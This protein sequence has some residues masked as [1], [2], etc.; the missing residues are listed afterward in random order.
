MPKSDFESRFVRA[1][2]EFRPLQPGQ[3]GSPDAPT[4]GGQPVVVAVSGG[5]DSM[6]LLDLLVRFNQ[7]RGWG[8][9]L[10]VAHLNH[11][12]RRQASDE[13]AEFVAAQARNHRVPCTL[14]SVDVAARSREWGVSIELAARRCRYEFFERLCLRLGARV[15]VLAHHADDNVETVLQRI[16]RGTGIRG[17]AGIRSVR[18]IREGS[19]IFLFRP[20]LQIRRAEIETHA[21]SREVPFRQDASNK[22]AIYAR[23]RL[24]NELLPL[25][26]EAYNPHVDDALT[27][28]A[29]QAGALDAYL[30]ESCTRMLDSIIIEHYD[31]RIVLHAPSLARRPRVIQTQ[32]IREVINRLGVGEGDVTFGHLNSVADLLASDE[33]TKEVHLPG[34]LRVIRRYSRLVFELTTR[35][36][37]TLDGEREFCV[38]TSG[39]TSLPRFGLE[40]QLETFSADETTIARHLQERAGRTQIAYEEWLD[41]DQVHPP[42]I[43]RPRR[44]G[45]RFYPLGMLG[46][47]KLSDF[48][49]DLKLEPP[50]RDKTVILCDQLGPIWVVPLRIDQR[51]RLTR[52]TRQVLRMVARPAGDGG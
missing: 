8:L 52:Q 6:V 11:Q 16:L 9:Q 44:A 40:L 43:A 42:L 46:M 23:N 33:G 14:E 1:I 7:A 27:R 32:Q 29:E 39:S 48:L 34:S 38:S 49:I 45:D 5:M 51:V 36:P 37:M 3:A 24:R 35:N 28:L 18:A 10:H 21:K 17:L 13:D 50:Q 26:R 41:A 20:L 25:L 47:K 12:L 15:V 22:E 30:S 31:R 19:D 2:T 4:T